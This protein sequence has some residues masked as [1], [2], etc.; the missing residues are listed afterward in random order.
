MFVI[1]SC[2]DTEVVEVAATDIQL[3]AVTGLI[4]VLGRPV[5]PFQ[6]VVTNIDEFEALVDIDSVRRHDASRVQVCPRG[7][8]RGQSCRAAG[9]CVRS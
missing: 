4:V 6:T 9:A 1:G 3:L 7:S 5:A 2:E 8:R